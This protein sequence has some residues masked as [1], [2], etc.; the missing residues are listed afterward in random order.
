MM[1]IDRACA[2]R[3]ACMHVTV[4]FATQTHNSSASGARDASII[5][6]RHRAHMLHASHCQQCIV[7]HHQSACPPACASTAAVHAVHIV[8]KQIN[9]DVMEFF[10]LI[11]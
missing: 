3:A 7:A 2:E 8:Q 9:I 11:T 4:K 10:F 5:I 1:R 6:T